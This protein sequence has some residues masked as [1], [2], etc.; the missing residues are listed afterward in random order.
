M[1][2]NT[3]IVTQLI[4]DLESTKDKTVL[5][6]IVTA[7]QKGDK[8]IIPSIIK[9]LNHPTIEV[10]ESAKSMLYDIK[11][12]DAIDTLLENYQS[13]K[14]VQIR[15]IILQSLWQSNIQPVNHLSK[16][17]SIGIN[18]T[19]EDCIEV[20]SIVTNMIDIKIPDA[21]CMESILQINAGIENIKELPKKQLLLDIVTFLNK[22]MEES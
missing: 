16:I 21:E 8:S 6:A 13:N 3:K 12:T 5:D 1:E 9:L 4:A 14:D 15:N 2:K 17:V 18:G 19:I 7:R 22:Y 20:Y 11:N 10:S